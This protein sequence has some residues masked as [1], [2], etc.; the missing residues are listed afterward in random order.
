MPTYLAAALRHGVFRPHREH[1]PE[2][3]RPDRRIWPVNEIVMRS[4]VLA[5]KDTA[6]IADEYGVSVEQVSWLREAYDL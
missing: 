1:E 3:H 4:L 2:T 6:R 5:G